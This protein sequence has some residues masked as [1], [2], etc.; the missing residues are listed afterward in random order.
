MQREGLGVPPG[1]LKNTM[2]RSEGAPMPASK[3]SLALPILAGVMWGSIGVFV[4][5]LDAGGL[6]NGTIVCTRMIASSVILGAFMLVKDRSSFKVPKRAVPVLIVG[7]VVGSAYMNIVYNVAI[8]NLNLAL[9]SVLIGLFAI[10]SLLLGRVLFGEALTKRKVACAAVALFGVV[11]ISGV[12]EQGAA[13]SFSWFGLFMGVLTGMMYAVNGA[14]TRAMSNWGMKASTI[15][16]WYFAI[17]SVSLLPLCH[18][19]QVVSYVAA[20][21]LASGF[22]LISQAVVC[23]ILPYVLFAMALA[24]MDMGTASTLE[25]VE[26][27]AAM[28][29]GLVLFGEIPTPLMVVGV[30]VVIAAISR[31]YAEK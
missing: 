10:W 13:V 30:A 3:A 29:F 15:N 20:D 1:T 25:L 6:D 12:L 7:A 28:V 11:L 31:I 23:A 14:T 5:F 2:K 24:K 17:G 26:P 9:S 16:F 22:W 4:R 19:D 27:A 8:M 21:P 18:W